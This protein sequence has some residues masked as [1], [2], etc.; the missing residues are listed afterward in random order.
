[1]CIVWWSGLPSYIK[2]LMFLVQDCSLS[3]GGIWELIH[4]DEGTAGQ[5]HEVDLPGLF[6][7]QCCAGA[8]GRH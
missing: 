3:T 6:A 4:G 7:G 1:M 8:A 2:Q 5:T